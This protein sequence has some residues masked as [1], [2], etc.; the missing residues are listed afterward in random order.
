MW[1]DIVIASQM[2]R[3]DITEIYSNDEDFD[4]NPWIKRIF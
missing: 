4:K 1:E 3:L 2:K